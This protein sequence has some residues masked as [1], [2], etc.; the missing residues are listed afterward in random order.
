MRDVRLPKT[1]LPQLAELSAL[2]RDQLLALWEE[3]LGRPPPKAA[4]TALILRA[5]AYAI[6]VKGLGGLRKQDQRA[7]IRIAASHQGSP[8]PIKCRGGTNPKGASPI[9]GNVQGSAT[10]PPARPALRP[11]TRLVRNWQ[12]QAHAVD[13]YQEGFGWNGKI[14]KSLTS[15]A[16]EITGVHW[17]GPRFFRT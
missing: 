5:V 12:G 3:F 7:L 14:Y 6:Q 11:G 9:Q 16:L 4:S 10:L 8:K 17:S 2:S 13:V 15:I 1:K